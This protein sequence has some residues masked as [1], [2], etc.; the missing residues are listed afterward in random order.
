MAS[1]EAGEVLPTTLASP[2]PSPRRLGGWLLLA[3][4]TLFAWPLQF[5]AAATPVW[6]SVRQHGLGPI[7]EQDPT[8]LLLAAWRVGSS[9]TLGALSLWTL[10]P[11][12]KRRRV[13]RNLMLAFFISTFVV[14][15]ANYVID[16]VIAPAGAPPPN[17]WRVVIS[18][19]IVGAWIKY[20]TSSHRV[21]ETFVL[22]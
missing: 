11:F 21:R 16:A 1:V 13:A 2:T 3:L 5:V 12:L 6:L 4:V 20:F 10:R 18:C 9:G 17:L 8:W 14:G 7:W 15:I 19:T 22:P